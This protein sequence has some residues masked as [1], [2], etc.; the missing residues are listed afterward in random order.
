MTEVREVDTGAPAE[1][2][3]RGWHALGL[4]A[5]FRD[6][7]PHGINAFGQKLVIFADEHDELKVIDSYCRHMGGDLSQGTLKDGA[8][9][10]PFHDWRWSGDGVCRKVPYAKRA[11]RLARTHTWITLE[12]NGILFVWHDT[13]GNPPQ[14]EV[15][16]PELECFDNPQWSEWTWHTTI[17]EGAH[18][19]EVVDNHA[20][21]AHFFYVHFSIVDEFFNVFDGHTARQYIRSRVRPDTG[22]GADFA[23]NSVLVSDSTYHG[24][25]FLPARLTSRVGELDIDSILLLCNYPIDHNSF[26]LQWATSTRKLPELD[27]AGNAGLASLLDTAATDGFVQDAEIWRSKTRMENP[28]L[29]DEDGPVYHLR[30]W[31]QQFFVDAADVAPEMTQRFEFQVDT[32]NAAEIW[33]AE[34]ANNLATSKNAE[35]EPI[36]QHH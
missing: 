27:D 30:R 13:E 4:A 17:I 24:P 15:T 1:R 36:P 16:I 18:P 6:G 32:T 2:Y 9:A 23:G 14:P 31:Y 22:P 20:D 29:T 3:A 34:V 7:K 12:R 28:L 10:C 33:T 11:P 26:Q 35:H 8:V 21:M 19:R 5:G 25:A